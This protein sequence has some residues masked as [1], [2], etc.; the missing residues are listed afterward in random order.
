LGVRKKT[1]AE[2]ALIAGREKEKTDTKTVLIVR[3][4]ASEQSY[5]DKAQA[6]V[7]LEEENKTH[8]PGEKNQ[9]TKRRGK[10]KLKKKKKTKK[11]KV[12]KKKKKGGCSSSHCSGEREKTTR[13][14]EKES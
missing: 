11:K 1:A 3:T 13:R 12:G 14:R 6:T 2:A 7:S 9:E 10:K 8:T 4:G 5:R